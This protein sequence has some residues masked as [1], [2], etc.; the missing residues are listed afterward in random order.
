MGKLMEEFKAW[1]EDRKVTCPICGKVGWLWRKG[2]ECDGEIY[3]AHVVGRNK[4][5]HCRVAKGL[6]FMFDERKHPRVFAKALYLLGMDPEVIAEGWNEQELRSLL[7]PEVTITCGDG[8]GVPVIAG[9][10][11]KIRSRNT[12]TR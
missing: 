9:I 10:G 2:P 8:N 7:E 3:V 11:R 5:R 1:L 4:K 12:A 6:D